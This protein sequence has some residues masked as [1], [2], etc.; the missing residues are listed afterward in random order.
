MKSA[1]IAPATHDDLAD[2]AALVNLAYRGS[3]ARSG[4]TSEADLIAGQRTD[5]AALAD[6]LAAP[7]P[8]TILLL[9]DTP[10][11]P[12]LACVMLQTFRDDAERLLCHL[13]MLTVRPGEQDRG[14]GRRLIAAVEAHARTAGCVAVEMTVIHLREELI[15]FYERRGFRRTGRTKPFPYGDARVGAPLRDDLHFVVLEKPL[16]LAT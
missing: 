7:D 9:R 16:L 2:V 11:G 3:S 12:V 10:D 14:L 5:A 15:A 4:W 13:A 1:L 8:S 6:E